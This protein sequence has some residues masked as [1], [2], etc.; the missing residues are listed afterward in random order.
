MMVNVMEAKENNQHGHAVGPNFVAPRSDRSDAAKCRRQQQVEAIAVTRA[1]NEDAEPLQPRS[2]SPSANYSAS[3]EE[4]CR[5]KT[6][7]TEAARCY[8][9]DRTAPAVPAPPEAS[10]GRGRQRS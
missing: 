10:T 5:L 8:A 4:P 7:T 1:V 6:A 9:R 3:A 2:K